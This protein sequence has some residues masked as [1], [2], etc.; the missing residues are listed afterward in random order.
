MGTSAIPNLLIPGQKGDTGGV[1]DTGSKG[2]TGGIGDTGPKGDT[3]PSWEPTPFGFLAIVN[4]C[5]KA[6]A[7]AFTPLL[8]AAVLVG[9]LITQT[10]D[11]NHP[12][13]IDFH[14]IVTAN[15]GYQISGDIASM[16]IAGYEEFEICFKLVTST[17]AIIRMGYGD[18]LLAAEHTDG[19]W[20]DIAGTTLSG[21]CKNNAGPTTTG[22][23]YTLSTGTWYRALLAVNA[24][25]TLVT[26][27]LYN[28]AGT[29]LW[30]N[31]VNA[32]IPTAAG[33]E[34]GPIILAVMSG[35]TAYDCLNIDWY[36][37]GI[38]TRTLV[39]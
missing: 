27:T 12:G 11:A 17:G 19:V 9:T 36:R 32:N 20:I 30:T 10:G 31:T 13:V 26:F 23:T 24:A 8:G 28:A 29:S 25:A 1:G 34:L 22:T 14:H 16:L 21:K 2:D 15:S 18:S 5:M 3:G 35:T 37:Y 7:N 6:T 4:D 39:R 38:P 33:R